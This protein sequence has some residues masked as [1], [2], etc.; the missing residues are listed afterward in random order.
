MLYRFDLHLHSCL[1]PCGDLECAPSAV[2]QKA[3][4]VGL[5]GLMLA[6]HNTSKNAPACAEHCRR[7]GMACLFG[8]EI[9][10]SEEV[11]ALAV[12]DTV[13]QAASM[14]EFVYAALP[15]RVNQPEI[16]G[17][18]PVVNAEDE[19][20]ELEWRLLSAPTRLPLKA[21]GEKIHGLGGLFIPTHV[22]RSTFSVFSQLGG[23]AGDEG[24]DAVEL[25]RFATFPAWKDK[26]RGLAVI[27][28]SDAH[29]LA[30][31]GSIWTELELSGFTVAALKKAF[32]APVAPEIVSP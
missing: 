29:Y 28:S 23:I 4:S 14:T 6:D 8:M 26:L 16:F 7:L 5:N 27:R 11:H 21:I 13:E 3:R 19:I 25:S 10:S 12:F 32:S 9:T 2:V 22:D 30:D 24:F 15:K 17:D 18:Q 1:S 20:E 31:I